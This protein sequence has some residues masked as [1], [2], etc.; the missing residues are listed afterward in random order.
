M[1]HFLITVLSVFLFACSSENY[2]TT[3]LK[4]LSEKGLFGQN[5]K[6]YNAIS[7]RE[8]VISVVEMPRASFSESKIQ[9]LKKGLLNEGWILKG[10]NQG[11]YSYCKG[12]DKR[13]HLAIVNSHF[14]FDDQF[15]R[16][17]FENLDTIVLNY[18]FYKYGVDRCI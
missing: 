11:F 7:K 15:N 6:A 17:E 10:E 8:S 9:A 18:R 12:K 5:Y 1:K 2:V 3:E 16:Y 13:I 4:P 14:M